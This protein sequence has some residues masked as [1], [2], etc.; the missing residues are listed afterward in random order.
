MA[1]MKL[2][3]RSGLAELEK[4]LRKL[5]DKGFEDGRCFQS[6]S[7]NLN[8]RVHPVDRAIRNIINLMRFD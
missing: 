1:I 5:Y 2:K 7:A 3:A 8:Y 4:E 6:R